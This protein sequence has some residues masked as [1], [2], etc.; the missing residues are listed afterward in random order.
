MASWRQPLAERLG[1]AAQRGFAPRLKVRRASADALVKVSLA[2]T[3]QHDCGGPHS[4]VD[5]LSLHSRG[6]IQCVALLYGKCDQRE[7]VENEA[8]VRLHCKQVHE[9]A[10]AV[11]GRP[12]GDRI[13][14][15]RDSARDVVLPRLQVRPTERHGGLEHERSASRQR[16]LCFARVAIECVAAILNLLCNG[17]RLRPEGLP[18]GRMVPG[19]PAGRL[20]P[21]GDLGVLSQ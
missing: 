9:E 14:P 2:F 11:T 10:L 13:L 7:D 8:S 21:T 6:V 12:D 4:A 17:G 15:T 18:V 20:L 3:T 5:E 1:L 19:H 16:S